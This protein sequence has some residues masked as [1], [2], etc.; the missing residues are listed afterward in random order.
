M[1]SSGDFALSSAPVPREQFVVATDKV[2]GDAGE[3]V[4][5]PCVRVDMVFLPPYSE[6]DLPEHTRIVAYAGADM[7][8]SE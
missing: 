7:F 4:E 8:R 6:T 5:E 1:G 3:D 2:L